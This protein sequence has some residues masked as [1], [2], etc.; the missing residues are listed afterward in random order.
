MTEGATGKFGSRLDKWLVWAVFAWAATGGIAIFLSVILSVRVLLLLILGEGLGRP[1][2]SLAWLAAGVWA[3]RAA[4]RRWRRKH[5]GVGWP[6]L[7]PLGVEA[8]LAAFGGVNAALAL[9]HLWQ[10]LWVRLWL[11]RITEVTTGFILFPLLL[12]TPIL[13]AMLTLRGFREQSWG[14]RIVALLLVALMGLLGLVLGVG[15]LVDASEKDALGGWWL[16]YGAVSVIVTILLF[17]RLLKDVESPQNVVAKK[18]STRRE[19]RQKR[20]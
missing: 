14:S 6:V 15:G 5:G 16:A 7:P 1:V 13:L 12:G 17:A 9:W 3:L 18:I 10:P 8:F 20:R 19:R 2:F 11:E 4:Y